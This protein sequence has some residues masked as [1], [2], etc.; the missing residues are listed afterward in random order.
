MISIALPRARRPVAGKKDPLANTP[1]T[2]RRAPRKIHFSLAGFTSGLLLLFL[3]ITGV[4]GVSPCTLPRPPNSTRTDAGKLT[5]GDAAAWQMGCKQSI[6]QSLCSAA[7]KP[8]GTKMYAQT[9]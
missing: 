7:S 9:G 1:R 5:P 2:P 8:V 4:L 3:G 6:L